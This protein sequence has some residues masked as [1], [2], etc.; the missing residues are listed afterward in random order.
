LEYFYVGVIILTYPSSPI[1]TA[2]SNE[3]EWRSPKGNKIAN[4]FYD[5]LVATAIS[6]EPEWRS[7]KGRKIPKG[8]TA[9]LLPIRK[10]FAF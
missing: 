5:S 6:N 10:A 2:I 1:A 4:R 7:P 9:S 8:F 3:P